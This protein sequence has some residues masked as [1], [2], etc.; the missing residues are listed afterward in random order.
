VPRGAVNGRVTAG[1]QETP[2]PGSSPVPLL[3]SP[4]R[5]RTAAGWR[6]R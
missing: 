2:R 4:D 5:R 1:R 6:T 3:P